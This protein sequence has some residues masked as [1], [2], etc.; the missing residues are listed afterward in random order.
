MARVPAGPLRILVLA[1][2]H[3]P[4]RAPDLPGEV[5][6]AADE[7]GLI[8]HAG[9]VTAARVLEG[10][11]RRAPLHA[12]RGN[13]DGPELDLPARRVVEAG[14]VRIGLLHGHEGPGRSPAERARAAFRDQGVAVAVFGHSHEPCWQQAPEGF[15]LLNPGSPTDPRRAPRPTFAWLWVGPEGVRAE[16]V[17]LPGR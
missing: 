17:A 13:L 1:D 16:H 10:L 7:A 8:L 9:D 11:A 2:T 15:W 3:V 12:V 5:W 4:G 6:R 14:G